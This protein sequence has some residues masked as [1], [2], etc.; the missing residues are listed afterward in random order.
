MRDS[1]ATRREAV[2]RRPVR[3]VILGIIFRIGAF[4]SSIINILIIP[5]HITRL[6][7]GIYSFSTSRVVTT[8]AI[9][10]Q[11]SKF[12]MYREESYGY[13]VLYSGLIFSL[14]LAP[15]S[16]AITAIVLL[17]VYS[18]DLRIALVISTLS[19]I[20]VIFD[21]MLTTCNVYMPHYSQVLLFIVKLLQASLVVLLLL[22]H[23]L[24]VY[25]L[26]IVVTTCYAVSLCIGFIKFRKI[27]F[28]KYESVINV[29][30]RWFKKIYIPLM[31]IISNIPFILDSY[32]AAYLLG[33]ATISG[34][35]LSLSIAHNIFLIYGSTFTGMVS[36]L[37]MTKDVS[38]VKAYTYI[39]S[40]LTLPTYMF[41]FLFSKYVL[42]LYGMRYLAYASLLQIMSIYG[43]TLI[44]LETISGLGLG[45]DVSDIELSE[46]KEIVRSSAFRIQC[47]RSIV[48][49][50][51]L[52]IFVATLFMC[53]MLRFSQMLILDLWAILLI[54]KNI[55]ETSIVYL[56][57][58]IRIDRDVKKR[59]YD[60]LIKPCLKFFIISLLCILLLKPY[61]N[62]IIP[63]LSISARPVTNIV[64]LL[65][66]YIP[67]IVA[68]MIIEVLCDS[69]L[70]NI[71]RGIVLRIFRTL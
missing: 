39:I 66:L 44:F 41:L 61:F 64:N 45:I 37:I 42:Y 38:K 53:K 34:F 65:M 1:D 69:Y 16:Y 33:F 30:K 43:C 50:T 59:L 15:L 29:W 52:A 32:I 18:L 9:I 36:L 20:F 12:W 70:R 19:F 5:R 58:L 68:V 8:F 4:F 49:T 3:E 47:I 31:S 14:L 40:A 6:E 63:L 24:D 26:L 10:Q 56:R 55:A 46:F 60:L 22:T 57:V 17:Y 71:L 62:I 13:R 48:S 7:Y 11:L 35:F 51:Y 67:Y 25:Y 21:Y 27:I 54:L 23:L 2:T 28:S